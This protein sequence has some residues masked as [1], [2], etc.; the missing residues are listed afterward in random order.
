[1][2]GTHGTSIARAK[3]IVEGGFHN[4]G[5]GYRGSGA[6]FW[7]DSFYARELA[8]AW[9][10][11]LQKSDGFHGDNDS[12]CAVISVLI[13]TGKENCFNLEE[14]NTKKH[15]TNFVGERKK[16]VQTKQQ[17]SSLYDYFIKRYEEKT[18]KK[19][20]V[21]ETTVNPP[22]GCRFYPQAVLGYPTC[23]VVR[24]L[25]CIKIE[26]VENDARLKER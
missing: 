4:E 21:I 24:E 14:W 5:E 25:S 26:K 9:W 15:L 1:M 17:I 18:G 20:H 23:I 2:R 11:K 19:V 12:R 10:E 7:A 3:K 16:T 6:Y 8:I 13:S 22:P